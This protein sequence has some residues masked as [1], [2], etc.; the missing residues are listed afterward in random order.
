MHDETLILPINE[1]LQLHASQYKQKHN[2]H[3]TAY[4]NIQHTSTLQGKKK[5]FNNGRNT[6]NNPNMVKQFATCL[7]VFVILLLNVMELL[8]V[9]AGALVYGLPY[10]VCAVPVVPV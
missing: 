5:I 6:T 2:V 9:V 7:G 3:H 1:H 8:S 10:N 4:I